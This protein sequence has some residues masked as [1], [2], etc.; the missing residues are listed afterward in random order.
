MNQRGSTRR[1]LILR[2]VRRLLPPDDDHT[3]ETLVTEVKVSRLPRPLYFVTQPLRASV[4]ES[5]Y[6]CVGNDCLR[7]TAYSATSK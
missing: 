3:R 4:H 7:C 2:L 6:I 5:L 1:G